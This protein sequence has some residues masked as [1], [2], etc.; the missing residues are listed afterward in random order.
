MQIIKF[1]KLL[2]LSLFNSPCSF[3]YLAIVFYFPL[4]LSS[5]LPLSFLP[6]SPLSPTHPSLFSL[7]L[8]LS[9]LL[10][11]SFIMNR[12]VEKNSFVAI[13]T[14][15]IRVFFAAHK[16]VNAIPTILRIFFA[17]PTTGGP[18]NSNRTNLLSDL[19]TRDVTATFFVRIMER[20][21]WNFCCCSII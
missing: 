9:F 20:L 8:F 5:S 21:T 10:S 15:L 3:S 16:C 4:S 12:N 6:S 2:F 11:S 14:S 18:D 19:K 1:V 13:S 7:S 17:Y